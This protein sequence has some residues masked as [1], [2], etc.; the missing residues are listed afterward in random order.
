[1]GSGLGFFESF[2]GFWNLGV[3]MMYIGIV[4]ND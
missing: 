4:Y 2:G 1:M 3:F